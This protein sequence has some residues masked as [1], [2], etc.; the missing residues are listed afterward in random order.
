MNIITPGSEKTETRNL[1][2]INRMA[3]DDE[4]YKKYKNL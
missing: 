3:F 4:D 2:K 1:Q